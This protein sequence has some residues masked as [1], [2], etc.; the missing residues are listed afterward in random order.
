MATD[1]FGSGGGFSTVYPRDPLASW[2]DAD[3]TG[4]L[5]R[6]PNLPPPG[7]F[8]PSGR[9]TPDVAVLGEGYQVV[10]T[11]PVSGKTAIQSVGGTSASSPALGGMISLLNEARLA[12]KGGKPMGFLNPF[13]YK[14]PELFTDVVIGSN[15]YGHGS[16]PIQYGF[17]CTKGWDPATGLG[18]PRFDKLLQAALEIGRVPRS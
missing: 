8:P 2:Q 1:Q 6:A 17:N 3:A 18:T 16:G 11:D 12:T 9:G 14:H 4:Y 15:A 13:I 5:E 10:L 7:S